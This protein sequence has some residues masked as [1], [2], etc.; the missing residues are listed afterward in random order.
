MGTKA[1][2]LHI[3]LVGLVLGTVFLVG[4]FFIPW[5]SIHW[6]KLEIQPT[7]SITVIGEAKTQ[8]KTQIAEFNAGVSAVNDNK[9]VAIAEVNQKIQTIIAAIK[10]F[11][12]PEKDIKTQNLSVYQSE[13]SYW[14]EGRQKSRPGQWRVSNNITVTLR[15]VN[16]ASDLADILVKNGATNVYGPNFSVED[17]SQDQATLFDQAIKNAQ[18]KAEIIARSSGGKL[19]KILTVTEGYQSTAYKGLA[20]E[21]GGGGG[22]A[23]EPGSQTIQKTVT[24]VFELK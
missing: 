18:E 21:G 7:K 16:K 19:G 14:E 20:F 8:Q 5:Q 22:P 1:N 24:V 23:L 12:I 2:L 3:F 4:V 9:D 6:G 13:E 15:D 17:T 11:G 10:T